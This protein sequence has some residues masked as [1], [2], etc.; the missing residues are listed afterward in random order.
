MAMLELE[1]ED[2][3]DD[4]FDDLPVSNISLSTEDLDANAGSNG[5]SRA[6]KSTF[7][8][9]DGKGYNAPRDNTKKILAVNAEEAS[10]IAIAHE[11]SL[12]SEIEGLGAGG[13][14]ARFAPDFIHSA[15]DEHANNK[16]RP[17]SSSKQGHGTGRVTGGRATRGLTAKDFAHKH[18]N[19]KAKAAKKHA[20]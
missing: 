15:Q 3:Y 12:K 13:N 7:Y 2:E 19:Q 11:K 10:R 9:L 8:V 20:I 6:T 16:T 4:S 5:N 1:Y 18:H 14:K 17:E